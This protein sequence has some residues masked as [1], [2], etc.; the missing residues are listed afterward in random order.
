MPCIVR[1]PFRF[2]PGLICREALVNLDV[3]PMILTA[4]GSDLPSDRVIDGRDPTATLAGEA[5][6]PHEALFFHFRKSSAV[7]AGRYKLVRSE[8]PGCPEA[9]SRRAAGVCLRAV[10]RQPC[11]FAV[12]IKMSRFALELSGSP[13]AVE[14][15]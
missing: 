15:D 14:T 3:F 8:Q 12:R 13:R 7:R 11:T 1:W 4:A 6:S 2:R 10:V 9:G 5:E